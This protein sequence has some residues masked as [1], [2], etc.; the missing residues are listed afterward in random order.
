MYFQFRISSRSSC[1][2]RPLFREVDNNWSPK[3][4]KNKTDL[5][6]QP[7]HPKRRKK[8][9]FT[10]SAA[11]P[12]AREANLASIAAIKQPESMR[13]YIGVSSGHHPFAQPAPA[14]RPCTIKIYASFPCASVRRR[15]PPRRG[16]SCERYT[17]AGGWFPKQPPRGPNNTMFILPRNHFRKFTRAE[18]RRM[19]TL[20][21]AGDF[22]L[23]IRTDLDLP[24]LALRP[25]P[26][27]AA[28]RELFMEIGASFNPSPPGLESSVGCF[29]VGGFH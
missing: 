7:C 19:E 18:R 17:R 20:R 12:V 14:N 26:A 13:T 4:K 11:T 22:S 25:L 16:R 5:S 28:V 8:P 24:R 6:Y 23:S 2:P 10:A 3:E 29:G 1:K 9:K 21:C 27:P 15:P